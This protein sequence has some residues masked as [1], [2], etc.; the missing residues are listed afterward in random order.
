[1]SEVESVCKSY[2]LTP[3]YI[4]TIT[5]KVYKV[6]DGNHQFALKKSA[7]TKSSIHKWENVLHEAYYYHLTN[8]PPVFL[9]KDGQLYVAYDS[10]VYY[11]TPWIEQSESISLNQMFTCLGKVHQYTKKKYKLDQD[12]VT[13]QFTSYKSNCEDLLK[14]LLHHVEIYEKSHYMSPVE[15]Q[16]CT[17]YHNLE[18][19]ITHLLTYIDHFLQE[20][21]NTSEWSSSLCHG[22]IKRSHFLVNNE[23][24]FLINW[25]HSSYD[26][27][28]TDLVA[29]F[30]NETRDHHLSIDLLN[31]SFRDYMRQNVLS[32]SELYYFI[33]HLL[34]PK[35]YV[36]FVERYSHSK[37]AL[38][39][40]DQV[41]ALEIAYSKLQ[42]G[43]EW[44]IAIET[45]YDLN[46]FEIKS[47]K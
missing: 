16:V 33:M 31:R 24:T 43:L 23:N 29:L 25:E 34:D 12:I 7:L 3:R 37:T 28:V 27:A 40:L 5:S 47:D 42:L 15:L 6:S 14:R 30:S 46:P 13:Q 41:E 45:E 11:L 22:S 35:P 1:M 38:P 4:T 44:S 21:T 8:I 18:R 39:M 10:F 2:G 32:T 26:Q 20:L 9:T 17:H 36:Q 19:V